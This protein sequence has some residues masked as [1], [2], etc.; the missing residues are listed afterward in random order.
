M[1]KKNYIPPWFEKG[2]NVLKQQTGRIRQLRKLG[3]LNYA[4]DEEIGLGPS[5]TCFSEE[6]RKMFAAWCLKKYGSLENI[7]K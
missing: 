2:K 3:V 7:S 4:C 5:Q 6:T 1:P